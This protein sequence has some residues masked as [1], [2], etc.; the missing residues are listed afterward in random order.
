MARSG[1][2]GK[3]CPVC[4]APLREDGLCI[5]QPYEHKPKQ[6]QRSKEVKG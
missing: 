1:K 6:G 2:D 3:E 5:Y 4:G